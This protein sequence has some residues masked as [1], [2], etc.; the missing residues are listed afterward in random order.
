MEA[1][2]WFLAGFIFGLLTYTVMDRARLCSACELLAMEAAEELERGGD[3]S[4][5]GYPRTRQ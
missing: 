4:C 2:A 5:Q 1:L 3:G